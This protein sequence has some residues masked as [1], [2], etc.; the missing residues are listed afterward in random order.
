[1]LEH[2]FGIR[3]RTFKTIQTGMKSRISR[4]FVLAKAVA[5]SANIFLGQLWHYALGENSHETDEHAL[6]LCVNGISMM[7]IVRPMFVSFPTHAAF[8]SW[9]I[10]NLDQPTPWI[11]SKHGWVTSQ[12]IPPAWAGCDTKKPALIQSS[13]QA[14]KNESLLKSQDCQER[15]SGLVNWL[16]TQNCRGRMYSI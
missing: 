4:S 15:L 13:V 14:L 6:W 9:P 12:K 8:W 11:A 1:M 16:A 5:W 3:W 10:H 2:V 7:Q